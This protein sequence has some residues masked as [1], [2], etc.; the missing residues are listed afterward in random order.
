MKFQGGRYHGGMQGLGFQGFRIEG[1]G[2]IEICGKQVI[3]KRQ[4]SS[5]PSRGIGTFEHR[6]FNQNGQAD[7][8]SFGLNRS[9]FETVLDLITCNPYMISAIELPYLL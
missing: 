9:R 5:N 2:F 1:L 7:T 6:A 3:Q 4:S 8:S